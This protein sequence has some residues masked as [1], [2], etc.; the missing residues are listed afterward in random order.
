[1]IDKSEDREE[2]EILENWAEDAVMSA[3]LSEN[4]NHSFPQGKSARMR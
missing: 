1:M 3:P 2:G 4:R